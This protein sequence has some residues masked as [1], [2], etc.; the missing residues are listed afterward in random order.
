MTD[1]FEGYAEEGEIFEKIALSLYDGHAM[2]P[3]NSSENID[4]F[5]S[6]INLY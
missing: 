1:T 2:V 5:R 4:S 6:F 3:Q